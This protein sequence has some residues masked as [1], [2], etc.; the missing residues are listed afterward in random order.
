MLTRS[1]RHLERDGLIVRRD[2][3]EVPPRVDY[4]LTPLGRGLLVGMMPL[5]TW[6]IDNAPAF[7]AARD[8]FD[9]DL[10]ASDASPT[11]EARSIPD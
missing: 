6:I 3:G 7:R 2:H 5:W 1:L 4:T 11:A 10:D 9:L 8:R